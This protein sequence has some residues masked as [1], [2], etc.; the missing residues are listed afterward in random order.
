MQLNFKLLE[1]SDLGVCKARGK[2]AFC[3]RCDLC[4]A[5]GTLATAADVL[6]VPCNVREFHEQ[7]FTL[8][9]CTGCGSIHCKEDVDL[10]K[11][12]AQY[13]LKDQKPGFSEQI[14]YNNRLRLLKRHGIGRAHRILD[15]GCGSGLFVDFLRQSGFHSAEGYDPYVHSYRDDGVLK[16]PYDAVVSYDVIEHDDDCRDFMRRISPL[17]R[18]GGVVVIGTPNAD[19]VPVER[20]GD[21][22]FHPPY[23]RHILSERILLALGREQGLDPVDVGRRSFYDSL[24]PTVNSRFLWRYVEKGLLDVVREAPKTGLV[25]RS[26]DLLF[27]AFFGYFV[28]LGDYLIVTFRNSGQYGWRN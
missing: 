8:W 15:Y 21:P 10:S 2:M 23:H 27:L 26:P 9:R 20:K 4:D 11:Y 22:G 16:S 14:G 18:P 25:L 13:P 24:I 28:P 17:V 3:T 7:V 19:R 5:P 6:R 1:L 12:Y